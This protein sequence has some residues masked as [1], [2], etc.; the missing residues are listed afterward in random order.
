LIEV[1][2]LE[3]TLKDSKDYACFCEQYSSRITIFYKVG[4]Q[5][6]WQSVQTDHLQQ[7]QENAGLE[8]GIFEKPM[9]MFPVRYYENGYAKKLIVDHNLEEKIKDAHDYAQFSDGGCVYLFYKKDGKMQQKIVA[10]SEYKIAVDQA[11]VKH[12]VCEA[13]EH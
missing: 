10:T 3:E 1:H 5:I 7:M 11:G 4:N 9:E 6:K 13:K 8:N 12:D 2:K